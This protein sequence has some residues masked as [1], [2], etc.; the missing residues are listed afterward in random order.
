M[1]RDDLV[2]LAGDDQLLFAD[3]LDGAIIGYFDN[4][5]VKVVVYCISK[6]ICCLMEDSDMDEDEA[7]EFLQFNTFDAYVGPRTPL[8]IEQRWT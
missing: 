3:G 8:F 7:D 5:E 2:L 4:G 6:C 1:S